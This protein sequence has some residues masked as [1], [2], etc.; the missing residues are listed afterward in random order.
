M[1]SELGTTGPQLHKSGLAGPASHL[2]HLDLLCELLTA[3]L[4]TAERVRPSHEYTLRS[5]DG[6]PPATGKRI[7]RE[8]G[9]FGGQMLSGEDETLNG[10]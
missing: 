4:I 6:V 2:S 10:P 3:L 7:I 1:S 8:T 9:E 5:V